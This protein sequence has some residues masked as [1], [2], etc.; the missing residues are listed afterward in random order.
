MQLQYIPPIGVSGI[1]SLSSPF[2]EKLQANVPYTLIAI[3]KLSDILNAGGDPE[4][5]YYTVNSLDITKYTT[6]FNNDVS[7]LSLQHGGNAIVYVPSSYVMS[8]PDI[9]G[10]P[11]TS[12][13]LTI[14]IGAIPDSLDLSYLKTRLTAVVAETIGVTA[15]VQT[16]AVSNKTLLT[17]ADAQAAETARQAKVNTTMTDYA[18]YLQ[19]AA[20]RDSALQ[21]IQALEQ[22]FFSLK[23]AGKI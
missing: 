1:W 2:K 19:A 17:T 7:I 11:Y 10:V 3:R 16:V 20:Q 14:P 6:D 12:L 15:T 8:Y 4:A 18:M 21:K 13:A 5:D 9:G 22:Y 23:A